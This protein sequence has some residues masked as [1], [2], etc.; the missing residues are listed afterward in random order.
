VA[1]LAAQGESKVSGVGIISR[2]YEKFFDKLTELGAD[3]DVIG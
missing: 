1:A 3:F 2:G